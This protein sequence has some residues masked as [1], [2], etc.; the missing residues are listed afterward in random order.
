MYSTI[1]EVLR[2]TGQGQIA[3]SG[4]LA[5]AEMVGTSTVYPATIELPE[6]MDPETL[7]LGMVGTA[8]VVSDKAGLIGLLASVLLWVKAYVA[9]L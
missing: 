4:T 5:R 8:T 1:K 9:Y 7:R 6:G 2:G 3:V